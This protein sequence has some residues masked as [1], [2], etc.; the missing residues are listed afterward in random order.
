R[1][2]YLVPLKDLVSIKE[3]VSP[4]SISRR[5]LR[6]TTL[7]DAGIRKESKKTPLEVAVYFEENIFPKVLKD[8]PTTT[9]SFGGEIEDTRKSADDFKHATLL[10]VALI[11]S[12]L[13]ILFQSLTRPLIIM[14]AIPFGLVGIILAFAL[15]GKLVFGF[16][17]AVG[18]L[19]LAGVVINDSIIMLTKLEDEFDQTADQKGFMDQI[20]SISQTRLR[21]VFLTTLTT[22]V[23]V[24]PTAYG[25]CGYDAMLAEMML[26]LAWGLIFGTVITL[27]LI[28]CMYG[29]S[30]DFRGRIRRRHA[31]HHS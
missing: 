17:S 23:G 28:P 20:A 19:G 11:Y 10:A 26:A 4:N 30:Q 29:F 14:L 18:A 21:A 22:V 25:F 15:H 12:I 9:L 5:D 13:A 2:N 1:S 8:F 3:V 24:L 31:K 7:I 27:V 6:R 16:Y